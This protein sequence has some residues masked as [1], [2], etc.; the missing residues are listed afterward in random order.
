M[1]PE[2]TLRPVGGR[3]GPDAP[4]PAG[5]RLPPPPQEAAPALR[6]VAGVLVEGRWLI[7]AATLAAVALGAAYAYLK[8]P[9]YESNTVVQVEDPSRGST[10]LQGVAAIIAEPPPSDTEMALIR[11][12]TVLEAVA[13]ELKLDVE[14]RPAWFPLLGAAVAR[15]YEGPGLSGPPLGLEALAGWP[16]G[17][18]RIVVDRLEVGEALVGKPLRLVAEGAGFRVERDGRVLVQDAR[19][20][21]AFAGGE[22]G[23][24]VE[25]FVA[26]L[27]A[28]PGTAFRVVRRR[29][30]E[31]LEELDWNL[32]VSERGRKTGI[33]VVSL[34]GPDPKRLA[35]ILRALANAYVRLNV[36][37]RS[38]EAAKTLAFLESQL[39]ELKST[40]TSAE[41]GASKLQRE[42]G[43]VD[44]SKETQALLDRSVELEKEVSTVELQRAELSQRFTPAHP[45]MLAV[46]EKLRS[47]RGERAAM[48][49]RMKQLPE[50]ELESARQAREVKVASE[51]YML[52]LNK[53]QELRV[54][55]SGTV[56]NVRTVDEAFVPD[57]PVA[58]RPAATLL[59]AL[60][61]GLCLG[62]GLAFVRRALDDRTV[63]P[64]EIE[65]A[66][67]VSVYATIPHSQRQEHLRGFT[68][69]RKPLGVL[70][71]IDPSD[72]AI[73]HLRSLRTSLQFALLEASSNVVM[74]SGPSPGLGKSFVTVNLALVLAEAD[75]RVL[76][77][78]ADLRRGHLHRYFGLP[79]R[80][81]ISEQ[82]DG[83]GPEGGVQKT[84]HPR[85]DVLTTGR[86]PPNPAEMLASE[87]FRRLL[88]GL[89]HRYDIV[90][91]DTPPILAVAD[92]TLVGQAAGVVLL[93]LKA[94]HHPIRE[95]SLAVKR[96]EQSRIRVHGAVLNDVTTT[97]LAARYAGH[98]A[99]EYR[100]LR[101]D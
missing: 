42:R 55:K 69:R 24:R 44:L 60:A 17:G 27:R 87:R 57:E 65:R 86:L 89:S 95:I 90:L 75:R 97:G 94:G 81:G 26:E 96:L 25:G 14:A 32:G 63:D 23:E 64:D 92:P 2:E 8:T 30:N 6:A 16:W 10:R 76:V 93:V 98:Y 62:A 82:L 85:L 79:R 18:E 51:L 73:E 58:P 3:R 100:S 101:S 67:G 99:Y 53:A 38:V 50:T 28:R 59:V 19:P 13:G 66:T 54:V 41:A 88:D 22:G 56:G 33:L 5:E 61:L 12:R 71:A 84:G 34:S 36:E 39:P 31:V 15:R 74:V 9:V 48:N 78:D 11:S 49:A 7:A 47:L 37:R 70:A 1:T 80:P 20:G 4:G 29:H 52:V 21:R 91:V 46:D 43:V 68:R 45:A 72:V 77:V 83:S 40:L 35:A